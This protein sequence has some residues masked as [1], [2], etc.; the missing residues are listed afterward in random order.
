MSTE[1]SCC[2]VS[3]SGW[4]EPCKLSWSCRDEECGTGAG[5]PEVESW[6]LTGE[7]VELE[8]PPSQKC[9][10]ELS[11]VAGPERPPCSCWSGVTAHGEAA[12]RCALRSG[13]FFV[14]F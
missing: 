5:G 4:D 3:R 12:T 14:F 9:E 11:C 8:M 13:S 2:F 7:P 6:D 1:M 10:R